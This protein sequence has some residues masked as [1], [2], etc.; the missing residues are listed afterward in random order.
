MI[1]MVKV[2]NFYTFQFF[3]PLRKPIITAS[4]YSNPS[5]LHFFPVFTIE[6]ISP[7]CL[8]VEC[9]KISCSTWPRDISR[10]CYIMLTS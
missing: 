2:T 6:V 4:G 10:L 7:Q 5:H 1:L 9:R 3:L 8:A